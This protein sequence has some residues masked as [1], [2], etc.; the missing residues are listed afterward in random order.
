MYLSSWYSHISVNSYKEARFEPKTFGLP[1]NQTVN[2]VDVNF[3]VIPHHLLVNVNVKV[4]RILKG[5]ALFCFS[6]QIICLLEGCVLIENNKF[7]K[8]I[9]FICQMV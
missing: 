5:S 9:F 4:R 7:C 6:K 3:I 2:R 1:Q 8:Q